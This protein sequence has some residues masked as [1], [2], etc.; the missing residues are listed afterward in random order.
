[1]AKKIPN[2]QKFRKIRE[3]GG[4]VFLR[5]RGS[6]FH[7]CVASDFLRFGVRKKGGGS[8]FVFLL[9]ANKSLKKISSAKKRRYQKLFLNKNNSFF[10]HTISNSI[11]FP[12]SFPFLL[13]PIN[14][15]NSKDRAVMSHFLPI[16][17]NSNTV[18]VVHSSSSVVVC[19]NCSLVCVF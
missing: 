17:V 7:C 1:M 19:S 16:S 2:F 13:F 12:F 10:T 14:A 15:T 5:G 18:V 6:C 8:V 11:F 3:G 4:D 9:A